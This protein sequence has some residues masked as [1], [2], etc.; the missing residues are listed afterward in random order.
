MLTG[1]D[2][3]I[4][5]YRGQYTEWVSRLKVDIRNGLALL[6][7]GQI[8]LYYYSVYSAGI[9]ASRSNAIFKKMIIY[10]H[11]DHV[12][13]TVTS[14]GWTFQIICHQKLESVTTTLPYLSLPYLRTEIVSLS[15]LIFSDNSSKTRIRAGSRNCSCFSSSIHHI[16]RR[17]SIICSKMSEACQRALQLCRQIQRSIFKVNS[18]CGNLLQIIQWL[19]WWAS[20]GSSVA[21]P[22]NK[23]QN[24]LD[25]SWA[26]FKQFRFPWRTVLG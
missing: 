8:I 2:L 26:A 22:C 14:K 4:W 21:L 15:E 6:T 3:K 18:W 17:W 7:L 5:G 13:L 10:K 9:F 20:M 25:Q 16:Q 19:Q 24:V 12:R 11:I 1:V 23:E